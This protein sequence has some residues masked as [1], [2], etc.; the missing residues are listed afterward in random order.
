[1]KKRDYT[2][3]CNGRLTVV[4]WSEKENKWEC[5][6]E[7]GNTIYYNSRQLS[8]NKPLS[9]GCLK[10]PD[11]IGKRYGSL[12][13]E[14]KTAASDA[15]GNR[16]YN[17]V[18]DCGKHK[19]V[20]AHDLNCG[21]VKSCG[22]MQEEK[23]KRL[24]ERIGEHMKQK[25]KEDGT[26]VNNLT[27]VLSVRN[28]SGVKGVSHDR[29]RGKWVAQIKVGAKSYNLGRFNTIEEAVIARKEAEKKLFS[30]ITDK[31]ELSTI[32]RVRQSKRMT[33]KKLSELSGVPVRTIQDWERGVR[34]PKK[35]GLE[36]IAEVLGVDLREL[37]SVQE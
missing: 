31:Q 37:Q 20:T 3:L 26:N 24:G 2:G 4:G 19:M 17:C 7:C 22:C 36:K 5:H 1:V 10:S 15:N 32:K 28:K 29:K 27:P 21:A 35:E 30:P 9:C 34:N 16:Y 33:Q 6:C 13:V 14:G 12:V 11:I 18:C 8:S 23:N 25:C